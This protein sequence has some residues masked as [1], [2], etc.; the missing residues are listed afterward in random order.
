MPNF[1]EYNHKDRVLVSTNDGKVLSCGGKSKIC[2]V[3]TKGTWV[4]HSILNTERNGAV[5]IQMVDGIYIFGGH[6]SPNTSEFLQNNATV[7]QKGPCVPYTCGSLTSSFLGSLA[8]FKTLPYHCCYKAKGHAISNTE[9]ILIKEDHI[10]KYNTVTKVWS[11]F[12]KLKVRR[13]NFASAILEG[14]LVITGGTDCSNPIPGLKQISY[15]L[16]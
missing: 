10:I 1:P 12:C 14:K 4:Q 15:D 7:W 9:L 11:G 5:A 3:L 2:Y 13:Q 6:S 8:K 16:T